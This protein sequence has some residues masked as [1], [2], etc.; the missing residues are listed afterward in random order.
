MTAVWT[1]TH[2]DV[3]ERH[4]AVVGPVRVIAWVTEGRGRYAFRRIL[5]DGSFGRLFGFRP[6]LDYSLDGAK[7]EA[8]DFIT[9]GA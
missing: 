5:S 7:R 2:Q 8:I 6:S 4:I 9:D 3:G 1:C